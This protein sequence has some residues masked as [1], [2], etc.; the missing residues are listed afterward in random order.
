[1]WHRSFACPV[2][3]DVNGVFM[4]FG[5][6]EGAQHIAESSAAHRMPF[7]SDLVHSEGL[8]HT[9]IGIPSRTV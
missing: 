1:M 9:D 8:W 4:G 5:A 2:L 7:D 3:D 6:L